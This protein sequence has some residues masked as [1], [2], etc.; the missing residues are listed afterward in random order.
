MPL[1]IFGRK[2]QN[3]LEQIVY[4]EQ[5]FTYTYLKLLLII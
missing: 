1:F 5:F 2:L 4:L 3:M